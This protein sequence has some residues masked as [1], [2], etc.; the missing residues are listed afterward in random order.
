MFDD[1]LL[2]FYVFG[3]LCTVIWLYYYLNSCNFSCIFIVYFE[4]HLLFILIYLSCY[5]LLLNMVFYMYRFMYYP[6][7][8]INV[9]SCET[10]ALCFL[11]IGQFVI[12]ML[13]CVQHIIFVFS[14]CTTH[15]VFCWFILL[16]CNTHYIS[17]IFDIHLCISDMC[18]H[19]YCIHYIFANLYVIHVLNGWWVMFGHHV[20]CSLFIIIFQVC[21]CIQLACCKLHS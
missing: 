8:Y 20:S 15:I 14:V 19:V 13:Y 18:Y 16:Y 1:Y 5:E 12:L 21:S 6:M 2:Y 4:M 7:H 11:C 3:L 9:L 10:H 17:I